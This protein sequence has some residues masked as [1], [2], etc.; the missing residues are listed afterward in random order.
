LPPAFTDALIDSGYSFEII[1]ELE[2]RFQ[3]YKH[4]ARC[5]V[6]G[7]TSGAK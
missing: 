5:K 3:A 2:S 1:D 6:V 4:N 7:V